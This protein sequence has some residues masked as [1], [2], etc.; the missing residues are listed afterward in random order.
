MSEES[1][2]LRA[3]AEAL[4]RVGESDKVYDHK[5]NL[6]DVLADIEH[7]LRHLGNSVTPADVVAMGLPNGKQIGCLT[8]AVIGVMDALH[9]IAVAGNNI[10]M[11]ITN[12]ES[13]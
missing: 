1:S 3:L 7:A 8:E 13:F 5:I 4:L 6:V 11:A 10:A 12:H 9:A 2:A